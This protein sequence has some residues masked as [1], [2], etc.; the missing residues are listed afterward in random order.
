MPWRR[1][2]AASNVAPRAAAPGASPRRPA[3][4]ARSRSRATSRS[5][6][7]A[8]STRRCRD[9]RGG[10]THQPPPVIVAV[11][12]VPERACRGGSASRGATGSHHGAGEQRDQRSRSGAARGCSRFQFQVNARY[13]RNTSTGSPRPAIPLASVASAAQH[14]R[15]VEV[16]R[17]LVADAHDQRE[18]RDEA[19]DVRQHHDDA[20]DRERQPPKGSATRAATE[21]IDQLRQRHDH[22]QPDRHDRKAGGRGQAILRPRCAPRGAAAATSSSSNS[23]SAPSASAIVI[24]PTNAMSV[25]AW[26][27]TSAYSGDVAVTTAAMHARA[28]ADEARHAQVDGVDAQHAEQAERQAHRPLGARRQRQRPRTRAWPSPN[29]CSDR[30][31]IQNDS[32]GFDQKCVGID[33]RARPPQ[34]DVVV[35]HRHLAGDLAVVGLPRIAEPVGA[36][37]RDVER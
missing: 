29:S 31:M 3:P 14:R 8:R 34:A 23:A 9:R 25:I 21:S 30:L 16:E 32:T 10:P 36:R 11:E 15:D 24:G 26:R 5:R 35:A 12:L 27:D 33:W 37:E 19:G 18:V 28:P 22:E 20:G 7:R 13:A 6:A 1:A 4:P 2:S 17:R